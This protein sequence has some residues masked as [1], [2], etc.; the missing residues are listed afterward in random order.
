MI[1]GILIA[2]GAVAIAALGGS[3]IYP[4]GPPGGAANSETVSLGQLLNARPVLQIRHNVGTSKF[5]TRQPPQEYTFI[6]S[7]VS[8]PFR[9]NANQ[10]AS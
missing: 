2:A 8:L 4:F 1:K 6:N 3:L 5:L 9:G 10:K 7:S